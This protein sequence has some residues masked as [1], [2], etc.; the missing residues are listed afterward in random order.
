MPF[1]AL[2]S[3]D[4]SFHYIVVGGLDDS[5]PDPAKEVGHVTDVLARIVLRRAA[6]D[7][8]VAPRTLSV[9]LVFPDKSR[10]IT[11]LGT[12]DLHCRSCTKV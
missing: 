2:R 10:L 3:S 7:F 4:L 8:V 12:G 1:V 6:V 5:T 9:R 11:R